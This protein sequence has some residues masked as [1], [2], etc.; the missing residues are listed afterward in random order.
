M[1]KTQSGPEVFLFLPQQDSNCLHEPVHIV[2]GNFNHTQYII[3]EQGTDV[4]TELALLIHKLR[5]KRGL[6]VTLR[7]P[8]SRRERSLDPLMGSLMYIVKF[9]DKED[10]ELT[11]LF[12]KSY[13]E[14]GVL[15]STDD[16]V[17]LVKVSDDDAF[18]KSKE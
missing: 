17:E 18:Q 15:I 3:N 13:E 1:V 10:V 8:P 5:E 2:L 6:T 4:H 16:V 12:P 14:K 11:E 9:C 7:L